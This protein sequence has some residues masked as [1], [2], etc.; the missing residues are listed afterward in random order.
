MGRLQ[1][2]DADPAVITEFPH[3]DEKII[4]AND[5]QNRLDKLQKIRQSWR[6]LLLSLH[7][8]DIGTLRP[9]KTLLLEA[10]KYPE[11]Q[12]LEHEMTR[13]KVLLEGSR[14][15][16]SGSVPSAFSAYRPERVPVM[17][18][19]LERI[20]LAGASSVS[21][22]SASESKSL[23]TVD[24]VFLGRAFH[25][26]ET[27]ECARRKDL[28]KQWRLGFGDIVDGAAAITSQY[29]R[30]YAHA[31]DF[32][33]GQSGVGDD[34]YLFNIAHGHELTKS[35]VTG[36]DVRASHNKIGTPL[37]GRLGTS[38]SQRRPGTYLELNLRAKQP[39]KRKVS[40]EHRR[41]SHASSDLSGPFSLL[42]KVSL[43]ASLL[44]LL[45]EEEVRARLTL[46]T[47]ADAEW[48]LLLSNW[49]SRILEA[50]ATASWSQAVRYNSL[51]PS[52]EVIPVVKPTPPPP[53][54][55]PAQQGATEMISVLQSLTALLLTQVSSQLPTGVPASPRQQGQSGTV[56]AHHTTVPVLPTSP[57][58]VPT[59]PRKS[60]H[61]FS[62]PEPDLHLSRSLPYL[63]SSPRRASVSPAS[64]FQRT[65]VQ[66]Q[67]TSP[68]RPAMQPPRLSTPVTSPRKTGAGEPNESPNGKQIRSEMGSLQSEMVVRI[69]RTIRQQVHAVMEPST[70]LQQQLQNSTAPQKESMPFVPLASPLL[71][72][73]SVRGISPPP[74]TPVESEFGEQ[75]PRASEWDSVRLAIAETDKALA[76]FKPLS[77]PAADALARTDLP[78]RQW[79]S[80]ASLLDTLQAVE[81]DTVAPATHWA[82]SREEYA[83]P[84]PSPTGHFA[85]IRKSN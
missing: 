49:K 18:P 41:P 14:I 38:P 33:E 34:W 30:R 55:A 59:T 46:Q 61:R 80:V 12:D 52:Q 64:R 68:S 43:P 82:W 22:L 70:W 9:L 15:R 56:F 37:R 40:R 23:E 77:S 45:W 57:R 84:S 73:T 76:A 8:G 16:P 85:V 44:S 66:P 63:T 83:S 60:P 11:L 51:I 31:P 62:K 4:R 36:D 27:E 3:Y 2:I 24:L 75:S 35:T 69:H 71:S 79:D 13:L 28:T 19:S 53:S 17:D 50:A 10:A 25:N 6:D 21:S 48:H 47:W 20:V 7:S 78:R 5:D 58:G 81:G 42:Y 1:A 72:E 29:L 26:I 65:Y 67:R 39:T 32:A 74:C 54:A